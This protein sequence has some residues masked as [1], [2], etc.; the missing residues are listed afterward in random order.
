M[1]EQQVFHIGD[2]TKHVIITNRKGLDEEQPFGFEQK[3]RID[4][5]SRYISARVNGNEIEEQTPSKKYSIVEVY[6]EKGAITLLVEPNDRHG[7]KVT[8][9]LEASPDLELFKINTNKKYD[10]NELLKL[11][12]FNAY[13]IDNSKRLIEELQKLVIK[14]SISSKDQ[15][16]QRGNV[17]KILFKNIVSEIPESFV[18]SLP[19]FKSMPVE[20]FRVD[21]IM[22]TTDA[23]VEFWLESVE[24]NQLI[25]TRKADILAEEVAKIE[26][27]GLLVIYK[28]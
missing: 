21:I 8:G 19:V 10:R 13:R 25:E 1:A 27:S 23:S 22:E 4:S 7:N 15:K 9:S 11:I 17:D 12:R 24:L 20:K 26:A 2:D 28:N 6:P 16:D 18:I 14:A 3:G 5:V